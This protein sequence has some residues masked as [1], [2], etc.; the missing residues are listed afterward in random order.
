MFT[1]EFY[2]TPNRITPLEEFLNDLKMKDKS[3]FSKV[4][5]D[6]E[7]LESK[8]N[9]L[10]EPYT[11]PIEDGIFELRIKQHNNIMR[12]FFFF[13]VGKK[14]ILT[15]G[16]I[17]TTEKTPKSEIDKAKD[18]KKEYEGRKKWNFPIIKKKL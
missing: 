5:R 18:Y 6:M 8:E 12:V 10:R 4:L 3:L 16:F 2:E 11:K 13:V 17:K 15:H 1:L 9:L 14:I 7:L